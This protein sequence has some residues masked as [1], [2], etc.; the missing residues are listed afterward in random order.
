MVEF[1]HFR[2]F[3]GDFSSNFM[4]FK[5]KTPVIDPKKWQKLDKLGEI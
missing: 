3:F 4:F 1:L 2:K 5:V